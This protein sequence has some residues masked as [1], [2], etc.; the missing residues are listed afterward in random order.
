MEYG[1][2]GWEISR[3]SRWMRHHAATTWM[4]IFRLLDLARREMIQGRSSLVERDH[5]WATHMPF[6]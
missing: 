1:V 2:E 6:A 5:G 4:K 3:I